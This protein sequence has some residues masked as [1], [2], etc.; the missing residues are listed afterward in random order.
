MRVRNKNVVVEEL[1]DTELSLIYVPKVFKD[2]AKKLVKARVFGVSDEHKEK[3]P[4]GS[5]VLYQKNAGIDIELGKK[6]Y[7]VIRFGNIMAAQV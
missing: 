2:R 6:T 3:L 4:V 5:I 7:R 1:E